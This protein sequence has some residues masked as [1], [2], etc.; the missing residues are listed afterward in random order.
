MYS[1][2]KRF[3]LSFFLSAMYVRLIRIFILVLSTN[4]RSLFW[5]AWYGMLMSICLCRRFNVHKSETDQSSPHNWMTLSTN[6]MVVSAVVGRVLWLSNKFGLLYHWIFD[7][8]QVSQMGQLAMTYWHQTSRWRSSRFKW[9]VIE[10][11]I[12]SAIFLRVPLLHT[13]CCISDQSYATQLI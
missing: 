8:V 12:S 3:L 9:C 13:Q 6:P 10:W 2:N 1:I 7:F 5:L 11:P 4:K